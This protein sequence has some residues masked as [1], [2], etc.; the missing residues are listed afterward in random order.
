MVAGARRHRQRGLLKAIG[1]VV[2]AA[3]MRSWM[4]R[5]TALHEPSGVTY[6]EWLRAGPPGKNARSLEEQIA[7][8]RL[9]KELGATGLTLPDLPLAGLEHF[10]RP[11]MTRKPGFRGGGSGGGR[12][13]RQSRS[14]A[15]S[16]SSRTPSSRSVRGGF[17]RRGL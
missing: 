9:L 3:T 4:D 8:V 1:A 17:G 15:S 10:A 14:F 11:V 5:L 6:L 2:G 13:L 7:K 16:G 12:W